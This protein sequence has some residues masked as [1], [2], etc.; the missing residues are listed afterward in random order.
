MEDFPNLLRELPEGNEGTRRHG[1]MV[2]W[3]PGGGGG[4]CQGQ[5][6]LNIDVWNI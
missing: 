5:F 6:E 2:P 4:R 3:V 1:V